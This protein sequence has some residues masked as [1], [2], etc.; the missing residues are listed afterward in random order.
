MS[1]FLFDRYAF[2]ELDDLYLI[3]LVDCTVRNDLLPLQILLSL[4]LLDDCLLSEG[5]FAIDFA[6]AVQ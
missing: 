3:A 2:L 5:H 1:A 4:V 6:L